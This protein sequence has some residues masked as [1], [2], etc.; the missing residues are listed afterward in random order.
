MA[1]LDLTRLDG[2]REALCKRV[3]RYELVAE[4][5]GAPNYG[6]DNG[7]DSYINEAIRW[8][9]E[10]C[11]A[12]LQETKSYSITADAHTVTLG[13]HKHVLDMRW[14]DETDLM[15]PATEEWLRTEYEEDDLSAITSDTPLYWAR[16]KS[17]GNRRRYFISPPAS[18]AGTLYVTGVFFEDALS[19]AE[20]TNW[21][22]L[23]H[24]NKVLHAAA[25]LVNGMDL[26]TTTDVTLQEFVA[27]AMRQIVAAGINEEIAYYGGVM[28]G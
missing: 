16:D 1:V 22:L 28:R 12:H 7:A 21:W 8:F 14:D 15:T 6:V 23:N 24:A 25:M 18:S 17:D 10:R 5:N 19:Q 4:A 11:S 27:A 13:A 20:D 26:N 9:E 3:G 2:M